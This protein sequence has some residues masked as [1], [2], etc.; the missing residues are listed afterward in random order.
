MP[1]ARDK[2]LHMLEHL[3]P[4]MEAYNDIM[5]HPSGVRPGPTPN[6]GSEAR[7]DPDAIDPVSANQ[8]N[9]NPEN[10]PPGVVSTDPPPNAGAG[11]TPVR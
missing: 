11:E 3:L 10:T 2:A 1:T 9:V 8:P 4:L 6:A 7:D 5:S